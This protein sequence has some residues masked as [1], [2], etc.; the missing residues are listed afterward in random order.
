MEEVEDSDKG[1]RYVRSKESV[2]RCEFTRNLSP[3][4]VT[5][6]VRVE[7]RRNGYG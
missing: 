4:R 5:T 6:I 3:N 2:T 1:Y 7:N